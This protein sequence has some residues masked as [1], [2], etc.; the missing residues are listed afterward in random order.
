MRKFLNIITKIEENICAI[1]LLSTITLVFA[2][3]VLRYV[4]RSS[5]SWIEEA[6]RYITIWFTFIGAA[7]CFKK[8][9]HMGIDLILTLTKGPVKKG[10]EIFGILA[11]II[12]MVF[13][14][15]Y[16]IDLVIF[17]AN[18]GQ[19]TPGL[20]IPLYGIYV[21]IPLGAF[22]SLIELLYLLYTKIRGEEQEALI[23]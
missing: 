10:I 21:G 18:S 9:T 20:M 1:G 14:L 12:F 13:L 6:V 19:I 2:N 15:K 8:G 22:L 4:F 16:G 17:T 23:K 7:I 3:V 5:S 11:S